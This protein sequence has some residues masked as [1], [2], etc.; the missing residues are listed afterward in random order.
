MFSSPS[1]NPTCS[2]AWTR[3]SFHNGAQ[4]FRGTHML[5]VELGL[6]SD[7]GIRVERR[8]DAVP[9]AGNIHI[10]DCVL[11]AC[12]VSQREQ[13]GSCSEGGGVQAVAAAAM[14][15]WA[16]NAGEMLAENAEDAEGAEGA[17]RAEDAEERPEA[18]VRRARVARLATCVQRVQAQIDVGGARACR[19]CVNGNCQHA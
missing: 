19:F 10:R 6:L 11:R 15:P 4:A 18:R 13:S 9:Q 16:S 5:Q 8:L 12:A 2:S 17:E 3:V 14:T 7:G 1:V